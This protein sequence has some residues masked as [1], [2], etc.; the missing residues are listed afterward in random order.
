MPTTNG[1]GAEEFSSPPL[2]TAQNQHVVD[3]GPYRM[4]RHPGYTGALLV[5]IGLALASRSVPATV[6][7][8]ALM[9]RAYQRRIAAEEHLLQRAL[10]EYGEY[11]RRTKK[12]IPLTW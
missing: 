3:T 6:L 5:W 4:I 8:A 1:S 12:L 9:G 10:P 7:V 2:R 11:S